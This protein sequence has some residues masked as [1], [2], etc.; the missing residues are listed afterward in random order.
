MQRKQAACGLIDTEDEFHLFLVKGAEEVF[1]V[2]LPIF[3]FD[4][5]VKFL[6]DLAEAVFKVGHVAHGDLGIK[7]GGELGVELFSGDEGDLQKGGERG[8][9]V[10]EVVIRAGVKGGRTWRHRGVFFLFRFA[11]EVRKRMFRDQ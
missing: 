6:G 4:E 11:R 3:A 2:G 7:V 1:E 10:E 5:G 9:V 8:D